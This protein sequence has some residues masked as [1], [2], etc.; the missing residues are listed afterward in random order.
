MSCAGGWGW[1]VLF[2][3]FSNVI[4]MRLP[5]VLYFTKIASVKR[6]S[7]DDG[8][9]TFF[10]SLK[11]R[12]CRS[13]APNNLYYFYSAFLCYIF[14]PSIIP[15]CEP[16]CQHVSAWGLKNV[17]M[18]CNV[19]RPSVDLRRPMVF[20]LHPPPGRR[21]EGPGPRGLCGRAGRDLPAAAAAAARA[22]RGRGRRRG[23]RRRGRRRPRLRVRRGAARRGRRGRGGGRPGRA[24]GALSTGLPGLMKPRHI[25]RRDLGFEAPDSLTP[26][27]DFFFFFFFFFF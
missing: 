5:F 16:L 22:A 25:R 1:G 27:P 15:L 8:R 18:C 14:P 19:S 6:S 4:M 10:F 11:Q 21:A 20:A 23:R 26:S 13:P 17:Q 7:I 24:R 2:Q 12:A 3:M 9:V